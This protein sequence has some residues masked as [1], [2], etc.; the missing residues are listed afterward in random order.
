VTLPV[1]APSLSEQ[2]EFLFLLSPALAALLRRRVQAAADAPAEQPHAQRL[3]QRAPGGQVVSET[4]ERASQ[5]IETSRIHR[6]PPLC[7]LWA[8]GPRQEARRLA[9]GLTSQRDPSRRAAHPYFVRF[10]EA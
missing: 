10:Q 2:A 7:F 6:R 3:H 4:G 8:E 5:S 9:W 1:P